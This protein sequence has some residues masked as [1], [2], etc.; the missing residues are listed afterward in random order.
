MITISSSGGTGGK[1]TSVTV[2]L[3][4]VASLV[5]TLISLLSIWLQSKN[6]RKPLLQRYVVR[7]LLMVPIYAASSWASIVSLKA[8]FYL[9]PLRDIYEALTIYTFLQLLVNFL[10][11]ERSLI[12]MMHGRTPVSHPWPI[13]LYFSK[14]DLSDPHT[15]L[16]IK[17]GILQYAW[18]K[19]ILS[20]A[21]IILK[22]TGTYQ[23]G[24]IGLTSGYFWIGL[25]YNISV[26]L[27]LYSLAMFWVCTHQDLKPFRPMPK[28]L[29]IKLIIFASYWQ[30]FFLSILQFLGAI[31]NDVPGYT[32]DNLAA[33]IQDALICFEMPIFAVAHWYAFSWHDYADDTIS[34]ARM[35]VKYAL[36]DAFGPRDLIEDTKETFRGKQYD[37]R[38]FD[39]G[40][41]VIAH[42]ESRSRVA[43]MMDGMR[44]ERGGKGKYWI[45][46]PQPPSSRT[47]LLR[48][49]GSSR[50]LA[51]ESRGKAHDYRAA[52]PDWEMGIDAEDERLYTNARALEFGDWN[53]PVIT[54][55]QARR[56]DWLRRNPALLTPSTNRN[57]FQPTRDNRSR[58]RSEIKHSIQKGKNRSTS[59]SQDSS[60]QP[61]Q[62]S[63]IEAKRKCEHSESASGNSDRSQLVDLVVEDTEAEE[64]E[65]VRARKE[66]GNA[67]N[68]NLPRHFAR[69]YSI[70]EEA[71][72]GQDIREGWDPSKIPA[73]HPLAE[74]AVNDEED[75]NS[76]EDG[77]QGS[78]QNGGE[79][80][81]GSLIEE[82]N[83]WGQ[84]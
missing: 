1:L 29:C 57:V 18:L 53:Y 16:A 82:D 35:P 79:G 13:N 17:R 7:I 8:A 44:Y 40:D 47:P 75:D 72:E 28:F 3:A 9:D 48:K 42:E 36:R 39:S 80:R 19:P 32:E 31:P 2:I 52:E 68:Q 63:S 11:G 69:T 76:P 67:W 60:G 15:F 20:V 24:Y 66:G 45:P 84:G 55:H 62:H 74:H 23:E 56:E 73:K 25:L 5:A 33:A 78:S 38:T 49:D 77:G 81:Y 10:G 59:P 27:S 51:P 37:Y 54:A 71:P 4:G 43:R 65:R 12:I 46:K 70:D 30:G 6:Y 41:N 21:T 61:R 34:A 83:V 26:T 22:L 50:P 14:V 58:R 64:A